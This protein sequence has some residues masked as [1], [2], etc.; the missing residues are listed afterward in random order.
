MIYQ[1]IN[2]HEKTNK[3]K[4]FAKDLETQIISLASLLN[5]SFVEKV[6]QRLT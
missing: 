2:N 6:K 3:I 1:T 5:D 4:G